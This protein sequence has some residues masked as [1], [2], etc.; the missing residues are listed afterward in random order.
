VCCCAVCHA[1]RSRRAWG[2]SVSV[3]GVGPAVPAAVPVRRLRWWRGVVRTGLL[4]LDAFVTSSSVANPS[5]GA[6]GTMPYRRMQRACRLAL[7]V[8]PRGERLLNRALLLRDALPFTCHG[9]DVLGYG[10]GSTVFR[11]SLTG[12]PGSAVTSPDLVLKVY[13]KS[14]GRNMN[15]LMRLATFLARNHQRLRGWY[16]GGDI[17]LPSQVVLLHGPVAGARCV[18]V[19]Q[20]YVPE[21]RRDI[22]RDVTKDE[23]IGL[24][25]A[26]SRFRAELRCFSEGTLRA[27]E[28]D[29][30]CLDVH[31]LGNVIVVQEGGRP[32]L[33]ILD[34]GVYD[35]ASKRSRNS[36]TLRLVEK[37]LAYLA[38]I[39]CT[40]ADVDRMSASEG[41]ACLQ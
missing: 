31:G 7:R 18:A 11:I 41:V 34:E 40:C 8:I 26:D 3:V 23:L 9:F 37:R 27:A 38:E 35:I 12:Q 39:E 29:G 16:A 1:T 4:M 13:R 17:L 2:S 5:S 22:F 36:S 32:R 25:Q 24:L 33:R 15:E 20:P 19:V 10:S 28:R 6:G 21:T 30:A 14:L